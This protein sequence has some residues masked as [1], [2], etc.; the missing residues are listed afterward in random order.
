MMVAT[1]YLAIVVILEAWPVYWFLEGRMSGGT[2][3]VPVLPL[4]IGL[5]GVAVLTVAATALPLWAG[6]RRVRTVDF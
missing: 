5:T 2:A 3:A 4:V 1:S 6:V